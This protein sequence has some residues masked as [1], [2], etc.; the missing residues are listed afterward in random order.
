MNKPREYSYLSYS[1]FSTLM[2][3]GEA[4]RLSRLVGVE[5]GPAVWFISG[6][7][8]HHGCDEID[9]AIFRETGK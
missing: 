8:F 9:K 7:A 1:S 2:K 6:T 4:F 3:C 5:E